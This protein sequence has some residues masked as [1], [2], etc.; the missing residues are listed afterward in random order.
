MSK[1]TKNY[2]MGVAFGFIG[3]IL[4]CLSLE[5]YEYIV[6]EDVLDMLKEAAM[7]FAFTELWV[8]ITAEGLKNII[9]EF[10]DLKN[11]LRTKKVLKKGAEA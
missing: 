6:L 10:K 2:M 7:P 9:G 8:A 4:Y 1:N 3:M 11:K 5:G